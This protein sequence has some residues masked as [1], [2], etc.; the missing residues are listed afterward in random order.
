MRFIGTG[1]VPLSQVTQMT[2]VTQWTAPLVSAGTMLLPCLS[3]CRNYLHSRTIAEYFSN[4]RS[5][6]GCVVTHTDKRICPYLLRMLDH[7][8]IGIVTG[9]LTKI[10]IDRDI[11][12]NKLLEG[13]ANVANDTT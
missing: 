6:L 7:Q 12:T 4:T 3:F 10:C 11:P 13:R 8:F 2:Q 5:N 1:F 9:L